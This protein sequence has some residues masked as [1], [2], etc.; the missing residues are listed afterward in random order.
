MLD[1]QS[2]SV[3][4]CAPTTPMTNSQKFESMQE[5]INQFKREIHELTKEINDLNREIKTKSDRQ[6]FLQFFKAVEE[7]KSCLLPPSTSQIYE[8]FGVETGNL[9]PPRGSVH[10][11]LA[12]V[13]MLKDKVETLEDM[14]N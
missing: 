14:F 4:P 5:Q 2:L 9:L 3:P 1:S 10:G 12:A 6:L 11:A 7:V 13:D 8:D